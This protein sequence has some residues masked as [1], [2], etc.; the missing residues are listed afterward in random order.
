MEYARQRFGNTYPELRIEFT[1]LADLGNRTWD[2]P[3]LVDEVF[4]RASFVDNISSALTNFLDGSFMYHIYSYFECSDYSGAS[5]HL[6]FAK[7]LFV[8]MWPA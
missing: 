4:K 7:Y 5:S 6:H 8:K 2:L 3:A 1:T